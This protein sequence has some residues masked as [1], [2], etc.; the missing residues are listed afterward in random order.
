MKVL[1]AGHLYEL[2]QLGEL[3]DDT[4]INGYHN[5]LRFVKREGEMYPGNVGSYPGTIIQEVLRCCIDRLKYVNNQIPSSNNLIA[6]EH[7]RWAIF[8]LE[9][10]AAIR[11]GAQVPVVLQKDLE[12]ILTEENGHWKFQ[13]K[14]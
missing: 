6:I 2:Q 12:N 3:K 13:E 14:Q 7:L 11:H 10:R 4:D 9:S 8:T 5:T 1:D